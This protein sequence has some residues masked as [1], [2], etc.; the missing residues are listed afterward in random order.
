LDPRAWLHAGARDEI[1]LAA[2]IDRVGHAPPGLEPSAR[3]LGANRGHRTVPPDMTEQRFLSLRPT[4]LA[5]G[6]ALKE[7]RYSRYL[8]EI[9]PYNLGPRLAGFVPT[10]R[11]T[12]RKL[13]GCKDRCSDT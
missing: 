8:R 4:G 5:D 11:R 6:L 2:R 10:I 7:R 1:K 9:R 3:A 12:T 13:A